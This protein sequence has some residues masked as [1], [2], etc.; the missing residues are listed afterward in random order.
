MYHSRILTFNRDIIATK[1]QTIPFV[2]LFIL[3][4]IV[5][6]GLGFLTT[7]F[8]WTLSQILICIVTVAGATIAWVLLQRRSV[9]QSIREIGFGTP[10]WRAVGIASLISLLMLTFSQFIPS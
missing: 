6:R 9:R 2:L 3:I 4:F 8:D 5:F 7:G 10:G 1:N